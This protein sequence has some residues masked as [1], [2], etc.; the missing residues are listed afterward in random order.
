MILHQFLIILQACLNRIQV[1]DS[2][3]IQ[4]HFLLCFVR[5]VEPLFAWGLID[6][7]ERKKKNR[8]G[9][10]CAEDRRFKYHMDGFDSENTQNPGSPRAEWKKRDLSHADRE[11][12]P[13]KNPVLSPFWKLPQIVSLF[14]RS[15]IK[16][17]IITIT[18]SLSVFLGNGLSLEFY[19]V[20]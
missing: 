5:A 18:L 14:L 3:G 17:N 10:K 6:V 9:Q 20:D 4:M 19:L 2:S 11:K 16:Q 1:N 13:D 8:K 12:Y 15:C 7:F